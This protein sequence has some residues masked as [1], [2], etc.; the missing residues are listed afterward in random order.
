MQTL[1][2]TKRTANGPL[3]IAYVP[4][5]D[6][7]VRTAYLNGAQVGEVSTVDRHEQLSAYR[8]HQAEGYTCD[9]S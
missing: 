4:S 3:T 5:G 8:W 9:W 6:P 2:C 1:T 7:Y